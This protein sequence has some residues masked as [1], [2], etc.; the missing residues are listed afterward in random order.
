MGGVVSGGGCWRQSVSEHVD[1]T[2][3]IRRSQTFPEVEQ[4]VQ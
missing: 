3:D 1:V 2:H 4:V